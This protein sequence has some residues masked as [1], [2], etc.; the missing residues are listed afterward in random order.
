MGTL[1]WWFGPP[2]KPDL[3]QGIDVIIVEGGKIKFLWTALE[4]VPAK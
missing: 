2:E 3:V 4:K 1:K